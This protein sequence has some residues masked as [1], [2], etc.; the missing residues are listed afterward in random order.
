MQQ[1]AQ[2]LSVIVAVVDNKRSAHLILATER[3]VQFGFGV[4]RRCASTGPVND[5]NEEQAER[6]QDDHES[7]TADVVRG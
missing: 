7:A 3:A 5:S 1:T 6:D 2:F 4:R